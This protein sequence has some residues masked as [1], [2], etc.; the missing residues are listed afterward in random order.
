[1]KIRYNLQYPNK[2][3]SP[4][5]VSLA[6][7]GQ[8]IQ[9]SIGISVYTQN[10]DKRNQEMRRNSSGS[11]EVNNRLNKLKSELLE[12]YYTLVGTNKKVDKNQILNKLNE[13]LGKKIE[14]QAN[15]P[16][17]SIEPKKIVK[18]SDILNN[19]MKS[20]YNDPSYK[21]STRRRYRSFEKVMNDFFK[22]HYDIEFEKFGKDYLIA[23]IKYLA[24]KRNYQDSSIQKAVKTVAVILNQAFEDSMIEN[25]RYKS[26]FKTIYST[27]KFK[28]ESKRFAITESEIE[29]IEK[30]I[31][32]STAQAE[33]KDKFLFEIYTA[34]RVSDLEK[35]GQYSVNFADETMTFR[36]LKTNEMVTIPLISKAIDMLKKYPNNKFPHVSSKNYLKNIKQLCKDAGMD[37]EIMI[38]EKSLNKITHK[39]Y[40]KWELI[41]SHYGR[42]TC[43]VAMARNGALA[44][45]IILVTGHK[46]PN[47]IRPYMKI[48]KN[49]KLER[50]RAALQ[51]A[52]GKKSSDD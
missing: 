29:R 12:Y 1:M 11:A 10:F 25:Q 37:E 43:V 4:I 51:K 44:E 18:M 6:W 3:K 49:E 41:G 28:T 13:L 2:D 48:A 30:L 9:S 14:Q 16:E 46:D 52:F 36:Q 38:E 33:T 32:K 42:V 15:Q 5:M 50:S 8:R 26:I 45:E 27:F 47:S 7:S 20:I 22:N 23:Y 19:F 39:V 34:I 31:P 35:I 17:E 24:D 40:K 21:A